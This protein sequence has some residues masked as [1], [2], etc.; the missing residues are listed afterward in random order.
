MVPAC[1][2]PSAPVSAYPLAARVWP[3]A[4]GYSSGV[5]LWPSASLMQGMNSALFDAVGVPVLVA[6]GVGVR[7]GVGATV[8][9]G[10]G[11]DPPI[12][13]TS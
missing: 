4:S 3:S 6:V 1:S 13:I 12:V 9:V 5:R 11:P 10:G 2:S 8:L 7:V